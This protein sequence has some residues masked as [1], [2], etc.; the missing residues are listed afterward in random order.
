MNSEVFIN[1]V[2]TNVKPGMI[3]E[4]PQRGVSTILSI[5]ENKIVYVRGSSRIPLPI[6]D[7]RDALNKF[8]DNVSTNDL[9]EFR[10]SVF[11]STRS[12]H[13]CNT[14]FLFTLL[15]TL[16]FTKSGICGKG[17]RGNPYYIELK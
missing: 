15:E 3:F 2:L 9:R 4:N 6:S 12:G 7:I 5:D 16:D 1:T 11:D 8:Q 14:T 13:S 10:P 17:V